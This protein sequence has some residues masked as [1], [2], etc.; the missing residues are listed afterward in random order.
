METLGGKKGDWEPQRMSHRV[1]CDVPSVQRRQRKEEEKK[2]IIFFSTKCQRSVGAQSHCQRVG[3]YT[4]LSDHELVT[5]EDLKSLRVCFVA[6]DFL[7][8]GT[9]CPSQ[10]PPLR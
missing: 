10:D 4:E 7:R 5:W 2:V 8:D 9:L 3:S 1:K 6:A